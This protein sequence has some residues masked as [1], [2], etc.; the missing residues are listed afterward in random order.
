MRKTKYLIFSLLISLYLQSSVRAGE[1]IIPSL[2]VCGDST[3]AKNKLPIIGWGEMLGN[4]LDVRHVHIEN[5]ARGG[6]SARTFITEGLWASVRSATKPGD[7]VIIQFGHNDT[8]SKISTARYDL[9]GLGDETQQIEEPKTKKPYT[10]HT[11]GYYMR[12]MI[13]EAKAAGA[14][15]I[16]LGSVPRCN[17][18]NSSVIRDEGQHVTWAKQVASEQSVQFVDVNDAIARVYE[19]IGPERIKARYFPQDNTHTNPDGAKLSAA[20]ITLGL[21]NLKDPT[22]D[23]FIT[24]TSLAN[25]NAVIAS[26]E[27]LEK[28]KQM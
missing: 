13:S 1:T 28:L 25:A 10:L 24:K 22:I 15:V 23:L 20:V 9:P 26:A 14:K 6:R 27:V 5:R 8:F 3:A 17:W 4:Y 21:A 7:I 2:Y 18:K 11:Y 12:S 19:K 16:V